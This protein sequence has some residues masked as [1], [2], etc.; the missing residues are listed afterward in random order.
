VSTTARHP[1]PIHIFIFL[2]SRSVECFLP[3]YARC[4]SFGFSSK[5]LRVFI[6]F[7]MCAT[8]PFH[9]IL[10][11]SLILIIFGEEYISIFLLQ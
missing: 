3:I 11:R 4:L 8:D 6:I 5:I 9:L 2:S 1:N 7:P 10:L